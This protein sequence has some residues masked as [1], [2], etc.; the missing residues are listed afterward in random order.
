MLFGGCFK[1]DEWCDLIESVWVG[2][3]VSS[4]WI[5]EFVGLLLGHAA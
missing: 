3:L 1:A 4:T 2:I 5:R